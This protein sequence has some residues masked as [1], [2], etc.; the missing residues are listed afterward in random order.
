[1]ESEDTISEVLPPALGREDGHRPYF[2]VLIVTGTPASNSWPPWCTPWSW[3]STGPKTAAGRARI[4]EAQRRLRY[5]NAKVSWVAPQNFHFTLKFLSET[6][7]EKVPDI[8]KGLDA[9][10][11]E[12]PITYWTNKERTLFGIN[13]LVLIVMNATP[14]GPVKA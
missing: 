1:V 14:R 11:A 2:E 4:A 13:R 3:L 7:Q 10:A 5:V 6:K 12:F 8:Q 9:V